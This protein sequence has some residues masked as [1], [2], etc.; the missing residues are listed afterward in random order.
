MLSGTTPAADLAEHAATMPD[1]DAPPAEL[2]SATFVQA[3][4]ELRYATRTEMLPPGL[5]PTNPPTAS[6]L[7]WKVGE[8]PWG[9]FSL[10]MIRIGCRSG[11][12]PRGLTIRCVVT[13]TEAARALARGWGF[14]TVVGGVCVDRRYDSTAVAVTIEGA[15][16]LAVESAAHAP[17]APGDVQISETVNLA[18]TPRGLRLVQAE[19]DVRLVEVERISPRVAALDASAWGQPRLDPYRRVAGVVG[20]GSITL[21]PLRYVCRPDELAFTGTEPI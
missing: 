20:S 2:G 21:R 16:V 4:F 5:H 17:L 15:P 3:L 8:S 13:T 18:H 12:R 1:F 11:V 6:V 9:S 14:P 7:A 19:A 10:A